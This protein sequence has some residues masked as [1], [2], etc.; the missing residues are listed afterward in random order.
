M[1]KR[2]NKAP[3]SHGRK[4]PPRPQDHGFPRERRTQEIRGKA[5]FTSPYTEGCKRRPP[6]CPPCPALPSASR[7]CLP[8][9]RFVNLLQ[10]TCLPRFCSS[11]RKP[12]SVP[13]LPQRTLAR[14]PP[15]LHLTRH[16]PAQPP[17]F[18]LADRRPCLLASVPPRAPRPLCASPPACPR[19]TRC[20]LSR[21]CSGSPAAAPQS[22]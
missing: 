13:T 1:D 6:K 20:H 17:I 15:L 10:R 22:T 9:E 11:S 4:N 14:R 3:L 21:P 19:R 8:P 18:T 5:D 2:L 7:S 12:P 16:A